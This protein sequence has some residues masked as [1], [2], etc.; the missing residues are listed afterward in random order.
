MLFVFYRRQLPEKDL[1]EYETGSQRYDE[2]WD[3]APHFAQLKR[4]S[5][6][7]DL[8][9]FTSETSQ[10]FRIDFFPN[11]IFHPF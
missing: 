3:L 10:I 6:D 5:M 2:S 7:M 9:S 11:I 1:P 8:T 4:D